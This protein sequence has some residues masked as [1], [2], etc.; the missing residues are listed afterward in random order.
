MS[1]SFIVF[2]VSVYTTKFSQLWLGDPNRPNES[3]KDFLT[4]FLESSKDTIITSTDKEHTI[5]KKYEMQRFASQSETDKV[6]SDFAKLV[7]DNTGVKFFKE[8]FY[9][10]DV[11]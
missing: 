2:N 6:I 10:S 5:L 3:Q 7:K 11:L 8:N 1:H 4:R 9:R